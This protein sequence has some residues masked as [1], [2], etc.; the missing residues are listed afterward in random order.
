MLLRA[1]KSELKILLLKRYRVLLDNLSKLLHGSHRWK[2]NFSKRRRGRCRSFRYISP[3]ALYLFLSSPCP[4]PQNS[5]CPITLSSPRPPPMLFDTSLPPEHLHVSGQ[6]GP[7]SHLP[8]PSLLSA[9]HSSLRQRE[10][11]R[12]TEIDNGWK[13]REED[14]HA[15]WES[16]NQLGEGNEDRYQVGEGSH[17]LCLLQNKHKDQELP[18][19]CVSVI[20]AKTGRHKMQMAQ[21]SQLVILKVFQM[22]AIK[23]YR[24]WFE[25]HLKKAG[26]QEE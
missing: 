14:Q 19:Y 3:P 17:T 7:D 10:G 2:I 1:I 9:H 22:L 18:R 5:I 16:W 25:P 26:W 11:E 13:L 20:A 12:H 8:S 4:S 23:V 6:I 21:K 24:L 15:P